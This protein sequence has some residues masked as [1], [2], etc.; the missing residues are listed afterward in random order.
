MQQFAIRS[1]PC[2]DK[3]PEG[4]ELAESQLRRAP[5]HSLQTD[6]LKAAF[7]VA[8]IWKKDVIQITF[9]DGTQKQ[10]DWVKKVINEKMAPITNKIKFVWD[11]PREQ[12]DIRISFNTP[13][14]AWSYVG[15]DALQIPKTEKTMNLG[16][17]DDDVQFD[18]E[19]Y[20]N[21]GQVVLHE[22]G[23]AM[24]MIHEHQN[25][26]NNTI[27]WNKP[28]V[29]EELKKTNGWSIQQVNENMF[30]KYGDKE[31]C[32]KVKSAQPYPE[33]Q[34][35]IRGY[36]EGDEVN[37][38]QYDPHSIMHYWYPARWITSGNAQIPVNTELS[39][40]DKEWLGKYYGT[41]TKTTPAPIPAPIPVPLS[42]PLK[43]LTAIDYIYLTIVLVLFVGY[44]FL[45]K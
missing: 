33:Q 24:G 29:Y 6:K 26:K 45:H 39:A 10:R 37:G 40:M 16:W 13:N 30:R 14:Q 27:Q 25:P 44:G 20:K 22:F 36:C 1:R 4:K 38:S 5:Q 12:S 32:N 11:A 31:M 41:E 18:A 3:Y 28:V 43:Q 7:K 19:P 9:L 35:D 15:T 8:S 2:L 23:H 34:E 21:T 42:D 17:L